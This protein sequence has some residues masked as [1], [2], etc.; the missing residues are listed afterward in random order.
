MLRWR[1]STSGWA[2]MTELT[3]LTELTER[4]D[5]EQLGRTA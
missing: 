5:V 4:R 3:E 2:A 1:R